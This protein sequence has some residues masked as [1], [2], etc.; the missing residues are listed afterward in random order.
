MNNNKTPTQ[1]SF[2]TVTTIKARDM[3]FFFP[4]M[5]CIQQVNCPKRIHTEICPNVSNAPAQD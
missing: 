3:F 5:L 1:Q 2:A 4:Q